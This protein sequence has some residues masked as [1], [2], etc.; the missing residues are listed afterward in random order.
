MPGFKAPDELL[1]A[2]PPGRLLDRR[3]LLDALNPAAGATNGGRTSKDRQDLHGRAFEMA[4]GTGVREPFEL[5]R[6]PAAVRERYGMHPPGQNLLLARR[7]V[8]AGVGFATV[9]GWVGVQGPML[10]FTA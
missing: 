10:D 5:E 6:E 8:E 7:L 1:P 3:R 9:N 4:S 2:V